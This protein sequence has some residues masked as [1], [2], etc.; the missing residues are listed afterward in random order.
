VLSAETKWLIVS[1]IP[2]NIEKGI[3]F[4]NNLI[5][6]ALYTIKQQSLIVPIILVISVVL[7]SMYAANRAARKKTLALSF[8]PLTY[9]YNR[10]SGF[11]LLEKTHKKMLKSGGRLCVCYIDVNHLKEVNDT[12]GHETGDEL[13]SCIINVVKKHIR[14]SDFIIRIGG[15]E[16]LIILA[17]TDLIQ[18]E[19]IWRRICQGFDTINQTG[20]KP[21]KI[22]VSH[23]I[24]EFKL[25][26]NEFIDN[27]V[28]SA[29]E[30]MYNEKRILHSHDEKTIQTE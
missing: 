17:N 20:N 23:G 25:D 14:Q 21:Y 10:K 16:F 9:A 1:Y 8:D 29:D 3:I 18:A 28:N 2:N 24:E 26:I 30:K 5:S 15:D 11:E 12:F 22:S 4:N 27:I 13:I 7:T 19:E 6:I